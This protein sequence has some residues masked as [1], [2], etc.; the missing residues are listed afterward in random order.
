[1]HST[2]T[3]FECIFVE[4]RQKGIKSIVV[5]SLYRPPNSNTKKFIDQYKNML[6]KV[7][8]EKKELILGMDHNLDLLK[9]NSH[10]N[11]Q[12][13]LDINIDNNLFP[14]VTHPMR[15][16]KSSATLIDNIFISQRLHKS[17]DSCIILH[18]IS[19]HMPSIVNIHNTKHDIDEPLEFECRSLSK[20]RLHEINNLLLMT[21]WTNLHKDDVNIAFSEFQ[22]RVENC[23]DKIAPLKK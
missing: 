5:G 13:F 9:S 16:T 22:N 20:D 21:D 10:R 3:Q 19:D 15:I 17:F 18:D 8:L 2:K 14:C 1:M 7:D 12:D 23:I 11:T 6:H 4:L